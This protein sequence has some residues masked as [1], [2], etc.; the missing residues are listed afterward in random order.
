MRPDPG[1][2]AASGS[3]RTAL[4]ETLV[5]FA[6]RL[7]DEPRPV[8]GSVRAIIAP[9][10]EERVYDDLVVADEIGRRPGIVRACDP[11]RGMSR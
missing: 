6:H 3:R 8:P 10:G 1:P 5:T 11:I 9:A 2:H 4:V 7:A